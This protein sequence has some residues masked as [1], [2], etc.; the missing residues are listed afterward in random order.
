[1]DAFKPGLICYKGPVVPPYVL[2]PSSEEPTAFDA[3]QAPETGTRSPSRLSSLHKKLLAAPDRLWRYPAA[4]SLFL[5]PSDQLNFAGANWSCRFAANEISHWLLSF[6]RGSKNLAGETAGEGALVET[7]G[8]TLA[9]CVPSCGSACGPAPL[10][11]ASFRPVSGK[12][13]DA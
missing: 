3:E 1:M 8:F 13:S 11:H 5:T 10:S 2:S 6:R 4:A 12:R 7:L 9:L